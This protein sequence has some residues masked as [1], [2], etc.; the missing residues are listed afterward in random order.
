MLKELRLAMYIIAGNFAG[1]NWEL[2]IAVVVSQVVWR[3]ILSCGVLY[4]LP[5]RVLLAQ[6]SLGTVC[7]AAY[8]FHRKLL[9]VLAYSQAT[10]FTYP[11]VCSDWVGKG[12]GLRESA[13]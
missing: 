12:S 6:K 8:Y 9:K 7:L 2:V 13:E 5:D 4:V 3:V 11:P 10:P 1:L